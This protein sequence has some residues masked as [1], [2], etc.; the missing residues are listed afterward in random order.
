MVLSPTLPPAP[1]QDLHRF[2]FTPPGTIIHGGGGDPD[3]VDGISLTVTLAV[4]QPSAEEAAA[5]SDLSVDEAAL[6]LTAL[7]EYATHDGGTHSR[8][9][10]TAGV[11][12]AALRQMLPLSAGDVAVDAAGFDGL[13]ST[14]DTTMQL[15][16]QAVD[17]LSISSGGGGAATAGVLT[18]Q[19]LDAAVALAEPTG[20][21]PSAPDAVPGAGWTDIFTHTVT[22]A[23]AVQGFL[24]ITASIWTTI[25]AD[26]D[27]SGDRPVIACRIIRGDSMLAQ[28]YRYYRFTN[29]GALDCVLT[30]ITDVD[31]GD[32]I[33][34]QAHTYYLGAASST[35][36]ASVTT[37]S[38]W[39]RLSFAGSGPAGA[40]GPAGAS[41]AASVTVATG[42]FEGILG[43]AD[44][45]VQAALS[46]LDALNAGALPVAA[47]GFDGRLD[48]SITTVQALAQAVDEL[49]AGAAGLSVVATDDTI[50]GDGTDASPL[51][52]AEPY[53]PD[54]AIVLTR[55]PEVIQLVAPEYRAG[56]L[57]A[58]TDGSIQISG[59]L[60]SSALTSVTGAVWGYIVQRT[61]QT[62][63]DADPWL[64]MQWRRTDYPALP[65]LAQIQA[66]TLILSPQP[67]GDPD[68]PE[69]RVGIKAV[70]PQVVTGADPL[71]WVRYVQLDTTEWPAGP[72]IY[73][74]RDEPSTWDWRLTDR[75]IRP[76]NLAGAAPVAGRVVVPV[77]ADAFR[78]EPLAGVQL[79]YEGSLVV[80]PNN[81]QTDSSVSAFAFAVPVDVD[82]AGDFTL[83]TLV[84]LT[85]DASA[86]TTGVVAGDT[87]FQGVVDANELRAD[88]VYSSQYFG[89]TAAYGEILSGAT[90]IGQAQVVLR[91][92]ADGTIGGAVRYQ[93]NLGHSV[94]A[95]LR[96][97]A[98]I[99]IRELRAGGYSP[100]GSVPQIDAYATVDDRPAAATVPDSTIAVV[101]SPP[102]GYIKTTS[103]TAGA[104]TLPFHG[105]HI[106]PTSELASATIGS[107]S[108]LYEAPSSFTFRNHD[109]SSGG[110]V[111]GWPSGWRFFYERTTAN[112][113]AGRVYLIPEAAQSDAANIQMSGAHGESVLISRQSGTLW[114]SPL[115][116]AQ[117]YQ[118]LL[119][120]DLVLTVIG[121]G[122]TATVDAWTEFAAPHR[123]RHVLDD[124][125]VG[126]WTVDIG[127]ATDS[128]RLT[129]PAIETD[130]PLSTVG[131]VLVVLHQSRSDGSV[132][133]TLLR[134]G[135]A[136]SI[137]AISPTAPEGHQVK[138][139]HPIEFAGGTIPLSLYWYNNGG[140]LKYELETVGRHSGAGTITIQCSVD[141]WLLS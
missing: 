89:R 56:G 95:A 43:A 113:G 46:T 130:V 52:V 91:K 111:P 120:G 128:A 71:Y 7:L 137:F 116:T 9:V 50:A 109:I 87:S 124:V 21:V 84:D 1:V 93:A 42:A 119:A 26:S 126:P 72:Q 58:I 96:F 83:D 6:M 8:P 138:F 31:E 131:L 136:H 70:S 74:R 102:A 13:L 105:L 15:V 123:V 59:D 129:S 4:R 82:L 24:L 22:A 134:A 3:A 53:D 100:R 77:D 39:S 92:A 62:A 106:N 81:A 60:Q 23:E 41:E 78:Y 69:I 29:T 5:N 51:A 85:I 132:T 122:A 141:M 125:A 38:S 28:R 30:A 104:S 112:N 16:A 117:Q 135:D 34:V 65:T 11:P 139:Q 110:T 121:A 27:E 101:Q 33:T 36:G 18:E 67:T 94:N 64:A 88:P 66:D 35:I 45:D 103:H 118:H 37:A 108:L 14:T 17:D 90:V 20:N 86:S 114:Q 97:T 40:T 115:L 63:T 25:T 68:D 44:D 55:L 107:R 98:S 73:L 57:R 99:R 2:G 75:S 19:S 127:F 49:P 32:A 10:I 12:R 79:V 140:N 61:A 54:S 80:Q 48:S 76:A 133:G 47:S